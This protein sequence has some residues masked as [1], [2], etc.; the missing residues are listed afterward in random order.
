LFDNP[1][2]ELEGATIKKLQRKKE[3]NLPILACL[4]EREKRK[5]HFLIDN[6]LGI[7]V[8]QRMGLLSFL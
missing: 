4:L 7:S 1:F 5:Y 3:Q 6:L 2:V 8:I